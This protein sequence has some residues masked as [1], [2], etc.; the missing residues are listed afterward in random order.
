[1][2]KAG[3][4]VA[5]LALPRLAGAQTCT[6]EFT[7]EVTQGVGQIVPG[8]RLPGH[9][10][11]N[12]DGRAIRQEGG[13][14]AHLTVGEMTIGDRIRGPIWTLIT[15]SRGNAADLIGVYARD[16]VGLDFAG[17]AFAGPMALTLFG[18]AGTRTSTAPPL[19]Q[20]EWDEMDLR[21]AFSL[22]ANGSDML[23]GDVL[24]LAVAC[25]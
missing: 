12:T 2:L 19:T 23:A 22:H 5:V 8:M 20:R 14:T 24:D 17:V 16:V 3:L 13:S 7:V 6:L 10:V 21:R 4:I 25:S 15:T 18:D 1:M 11:F 9:A